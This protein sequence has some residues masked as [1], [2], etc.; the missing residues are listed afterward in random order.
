MSGEDTAGNDFSGQD[1]SWAGGADRSCCEDSPSVSTCLSSRAGSLVFED[2]TS[3]IREDP[4]ASLGG[5][6]FFVSFSAEDSSIS[7]RQLSWEIASFDISS[8]HTESS[9]ALDVLSA[10]AFPH[11]H[12]RQRT[13]AS[14]RPGRIPVHAFLFCIRFFFIFLPS[15][16]I[17]DGSARPPDPSRIPAGTGSY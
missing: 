8:A 4:S 6:G 13:A 12:A 3:V 5:R 14:S 2:S 9:S 17:N 1:A 15:G 11:P 7:G 10:F 16:P